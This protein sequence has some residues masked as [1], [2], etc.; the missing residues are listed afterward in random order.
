MSSDPKD[1]RLRS[2][3]YITTDSTSF[4]IDCG[5][6]FR[7]QALKFGLK[8]IDCILITHKHNDHIG[9]LDDVR[10][11]NYFQNKV[12]RLYGSTDSLTDIKK[13]F[14][15]SFDKTPYRGAP[16]FELIE[17]NC[18]DEID[19]NGNK[20][21]I[22]EGSHGEMQVFG[23]RINDFSYLTDFKNISEK[24]IEKLTG[25]KILVVNALMPEKEHRLHYNLKE[26]L[27]LANRIKPSKVYL[28]HLSHHYD[29]YEFFSDTLPEN[30]FMTYDGLELNIQIDNLKK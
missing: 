28:T 5:P 14:Y 25:T 19:V 11:F 7:Q 12:M 27:E 8:K 20:I 6:D 23:Y 4:I 22:I 17:I 9:G 10:P 30:V 29:M 1:K 3:I 15:Y 13:R 24:E 26:A 21:K 16:K 2:S 18:N